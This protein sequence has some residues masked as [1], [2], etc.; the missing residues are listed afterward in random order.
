MGQSTHA[1]LL[2]TVVGL[3]MGISGD[4][5]GDGYLANQLMRLNSGTW[6]IDV[7]KAD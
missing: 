3:E 2:A 4:G 6:V 1:I 5:V 7:T